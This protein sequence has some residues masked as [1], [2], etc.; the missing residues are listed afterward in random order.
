MIA[1]PL[2]TLQRNQSK[3]HS[4]K[5]SGAATA[6]VTEF[7]VKDGVSKFVSEIFEKTV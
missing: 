7:S 2:E 5:G 1:L 4:S 6:G 3:N